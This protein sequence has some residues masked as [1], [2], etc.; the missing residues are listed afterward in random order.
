MLTA[1]QKTRVTLAIMGLL[2]VAAALWLRLAWL[3]ILHPD[4]WVSIA[5]RQHIQVLELQP[6]RGAILDRNLRPLA[7]S[8]RLTSVFA[9]P[10]HVKN[11]AAA[12]RFL[13][14][15]LKQ[16]EGVLKAQLSRKDRGFAWLARRIP[17]QTAQ[18]IRS[19]RLPGV[20]LMMEPKRFYPHGRLA[21]HL[22]GFAGLDAQGLEGLELAYDRL[23]KGEPGWRWMERDARQRA[24]GAWELATVRPRDGLQ[25]ILTLDTTIQFFA[26]QGLDWVWERYYPKA[27]SIVVTDPFTG[28]ILALANRP[29]FDPNL[30]DQSGPEDRRNRAV[31]DMFEPGSVFKIVTAAVALGTKRIRP[32]DTFHCENG[33]YAV[34]GR[35]L[36]DHRGHGLLTFRE[37]ITQSS[38]IGVA[39]AAMQLGPNALY[40]GIC[41]FGFGRPT[42]V[43]LPGEVGGTVKHPSRW[44]RPTITTVPMGHEIAVNALQLAQAVSVVANGGLLIRPRIVKE[45]RDPSGAVVE[46]T[47]TQIVR[48]VVTTEVAEQ[49][50]AFLVGVVEEGTGKLAAVPGF[51]VGGK[52]GTAQ[53]TEPGGGYSHS[54]F[55]AS[56]IGFA[57]A[58]VPR[59]CIVVVVDEP[60]SM[61]YG[62]VVAAPVFSQVAA[63]TL[64]YLGYRPALVTAKNEQ[65]SL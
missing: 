35:V 18:K 55:M 19:R 32:E 11:P 42:G 22:I 52:T 33:A 57:P 61:H 4:H 15:L 21:S 50:K 31:T 40:R 17:N 54:R 24:V 3:Q 62:G 30:F 45:I 38:N 46:R 20:H 10:R 8:L 29:S 65:D 51:R 16:P 25:L 26:E 36:H 9:D 2:M 5:R 47:K 64:A 27:A 13:A 6:A 43:E 63:H 56:F 12:A 7:V 59:V 58:Q 44:S 41:A 48:R 1:A 53:K 14:P 49:L 60:R 39:K 37:V 28:E 34:A 23:L